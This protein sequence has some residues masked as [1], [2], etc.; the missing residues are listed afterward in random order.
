MC[1]RCIAQC[2]SVH[3]MQDKKITARLHSEFAT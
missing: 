1:A 3:G 2:L